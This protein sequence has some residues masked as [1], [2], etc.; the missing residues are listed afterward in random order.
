VKIV[1]L[2]LLFCALFAEPLKVP[3]EF[4]SGYG[5]FVPTCDPYP[6]MTDMSFSG[7]SDHVIDQSTEW[8]DP[9]DV[10]QGDIV[11]LNVWYMEWFE[12]IVHDAIQHPYI[13]ITRDVGDWL[14]HPD[15]KRL[16]YDP[17]L[18]AW[19][20]RNLVFSYH[21]KLFQLPMGP[22]DR[23]LQDLEF[24]YLLELIAKKS[25]EKRHF[26]Y[27]NFLPRPFGDRDQIFKLF[28]N[29]SY[30]FSRNHS[31]QLYA[32]ISKKRYYDEL[33]ASQFTLS[34]LGLETDCVR[35]WEALVLQSIPIVEHTFLDPLF[36][37]L[38]V[39]FVHEWNEIDEP[40]LKRK[41]QELKNQTLEKMFFP[42]WRDKI[43][44]AQEKVRNNDLSFSQLEATQ[45]HPQELS[46]LTSLLEGNTAVIYRGFL[47]G[48][49]AL[50]LAD[51]APFL[52]KIH[53]CDPW[54][55]QKALRSFGPHLKGL[56]KNQK[57][58]S[59]ISFKTFDTLFANLSQNGYSIFFDFSYYRN[60]LVRDPTLK[61][62]RHS[63][64]KDL[65]DMYK[66]A[67]AGTLLCG[68]MKNNEYVREV[69]EKFSQDVNR[70]IETRGN[71]WFLRK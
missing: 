48:V 65:N 8:F 67:I 59:L 17:K 58:I 45:M 42:Y 56:M 5:K 24:P 14:P 13:L 37:G 23:I 26:L 30:C 33:A 54:L 22:Y 47:S 29:K 19:F 69:L 62:F 66:S 1:P 20:C 52:S 57:K 7:V 3:Q 35:T 28:E 12:K 36:E 4:Y 55:D 64:R 32:Q 39:I 46:D 27:M 31:N 25:L 10:L 49:H 60:S 6:L 16:L 40:F 11:Y 51:A 63:L 50:Q 43:L 9:A 38:P 61:N 15:Y 68:N 2:L 70:P 41:S 71:L 53:L 34:P 21:P 18:A 44:A